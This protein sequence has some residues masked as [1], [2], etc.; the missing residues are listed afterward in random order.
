[1]RQWI[2][3]VAVAVAV[4][5]V[6]PAM[7][8]TTETKFLNGLVGTWTGSGTVKG[9]DSGGVDCTIKFSPNN[10]G[11][12]FNG[13]CLT[14]LGPPQITRGTISYNDKAKRYEAASKGQ[15]SVGAKSGGTVTF[16][17]SMKDPM[18]GSGTSSMKIGTSQII[19]DTTINRTGPS[20]GA[21]V[22]HIVLKK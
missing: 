1:M 19:T 11:V 14:D 17:I 22:A 6:G 5:S 7:A 20:A 15:V 16:V 12:A 21:Y 13:Q 4:L 9:P 3:G 2:F 8:G 10:A 18:I